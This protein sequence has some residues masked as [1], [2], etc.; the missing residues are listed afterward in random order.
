MHVKDMEYQ[1]AVKDYEQ[2]VM[3]HGYDELLKI[4]NEEVIMENVDN[5][6]LRLGRRY[7]VFWKDDNGS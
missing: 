7:L 5:L 2:I 3:K 1:T 6:G 4:W